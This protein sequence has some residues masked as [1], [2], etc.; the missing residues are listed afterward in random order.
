MVIFPKPTNFQR[1]R[2]NRIC[3]KCII[4]AE[5]FNSDVI[6]LIYSKE[7]LTVM[8]SMLDVCTTINS[9]RN[10]ALECENQ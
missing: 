5:S 8:L 9:Q 3:A 7:D 10:R 1:D 6:C 2:G 4:D